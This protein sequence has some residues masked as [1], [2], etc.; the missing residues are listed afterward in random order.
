MKLESDE[1]ITKLEKLWSKNRICPIC[2][3]NQWTVN[4]TIFELREFQGGD[5]VVGAGQVYPI[6][7]IMCSNCGYSIFLNAIISGAYPAQKQQEKTE[8][9]N[10]ENK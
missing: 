4:D 9:A 3:N 1:Y 8:D 7:P 5:L 10:K 2:G 6:V